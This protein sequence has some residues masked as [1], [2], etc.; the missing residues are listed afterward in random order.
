MRNNWWPRPKRLAVLVL[1]TYYNSFLEALKL[2]GWRCIHCSLYHKQTRC[3]YRPIDLLTF[4]PACFTPPSPSNPFWA[5]LFIHTPPLSFTNYCCDFF[6]L[7][8]P[9]FKYY[10]FKIKPNLMTHLL[11]KPTKS[12]QA[13]AEHFF[14]F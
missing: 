6:L 7:I 9:L 13:V 8:I 14:H 10:F 2:A 12:Y 11:N 3:S 1:S 5:L 4:W